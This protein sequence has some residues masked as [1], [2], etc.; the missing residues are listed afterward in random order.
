MEE[1]DILIT[2]L[3]QRGLKLTDQRQEVLDVFLDTEKHLTVEELYDLVKK[4]NPVIGHATVFRTLKL[5]CEA[6]IA[7]E[8][9]FGDRKIR[10]EHKYGHK[11]HSHLICLKCGK[12]IEVDSLNVATINARLCKPTGFKPEKYRME[13]FGY[14]KQCVK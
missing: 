14:C 13:I 10:Y 6:D 9:D 5:M 2:F 4:K 11:E 1:R 8:V 3:K 7:K 12:T